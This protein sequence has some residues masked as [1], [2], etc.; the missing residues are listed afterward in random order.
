M[1]SL[2]NGVYDVGCGCY[3]P[4]FS[5]ESTSYWERSLFQR[6]CVMFEFEGFPEPGPNQAAWDKDAFLYGLFRMGFLVAFR[7]KTYGI[8]PQPGAPAGIG[9][10]YQPTG[11]TVATPYFQFP[12]PLIIGVECMPI[13]LTPDY[14]GIWDI[15]RKFAD[16]L[17]LADIAIRQASIN[18]RFAYAI[19]APNRKRA[20]TARAIMEKLANGENVIYD[21]TMSKNPETGEYAEPWHQFDRDLKKNFILPDLLLCRRMIVSDFY[22]EIGIK[23]APDKKERQIKSEQEAY[24]SETFNRREV[25]NV[26]LQESIQRYNDM[27]GQNLRVTYNERR[28]EDAP[29]D[30]PDSRSAE[31]N[32]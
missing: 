8:L 29:I 6:M 19:A 18:S 25:W 24:D 13:K 21:N 20:D 14:R 1:Y 4:T 16:Q 22:S 3:Q 30:E 17:A 32:R 15:V 10:M 2:Y 5:A 7:S 12:R 11:M 23:I 26:A 9:L 28:G 31:P 27:F